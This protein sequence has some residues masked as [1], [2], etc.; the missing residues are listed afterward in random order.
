MGKSKPQFISVDEALKKF[1]SCV[2]PVTRT[3]RVPLEEADGRVL[4]SDVIAPLDYP[5]YDQCILD[6]YAVVAADTVEHEKTLTLSAEEPVRSGHCKTVHTGSAMPPGADALLPIE[7]ALE[8]DNQV[9]VLQTVEK[10]KWIW[11]KGAGLRTGETMHKSG[12]HLTPTDIA[13]LAKLG[14]THVEVYDRPRVLIVPTGDECVKLGGELRDGYVYEVNGLM[15]QLLVKRYGGDAAIST[16]VPDSVEELRDA[17]WQGVDYDLVVTIG[18]SSS[19]KRDLMMQAVAAAGA[20]LFHGV[21]LHP[22]NHMGAGYFTDNG[23][24]KPVLFLSGYTESCA[25]AAFTFVNAAVR[26]LGHYPPTIYPT[27]PI[28]LDAA[29]AAPDIIRAVRK[30]HISNGRARQ[31]RLIAE[32]REVGGY[33]YIIVPEGISNL[34]AGQTVEA[35]YFE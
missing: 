23:A 11:P 10:G 15:C 21:A 25:V 31:I 14:I 13:M 5:H 29:V 30:V 34:E 24:K 17:V 8:K 16:I 19:G 6:G 12:M 35:V 27:E 9:V 3:V 22:G 26:K 7:E 4:S 18:G 2:E 20:V 1:L 33:T 28:V 32:S